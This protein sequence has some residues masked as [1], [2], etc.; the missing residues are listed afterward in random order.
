MTGRR[1]TAAIAANVAVAVFILGSCVDPNAQSPG[2]QTPAPATDQPI[3]LDDTGP[4]AAAAPAPRR[5]R[6]RQPPRRAGRRRRAAV[7]AVEPARRGNAYTDRFARALERHPQP[8][9]RL[10]QPRGRALSRRRD[11]ALRGARLR[12][13][14]DVRG[15][16]LLA[17]A[18]GRL[19]KGDAR[20]GTLDRAWKNMERYI[21]PTQADQPT[22]MAYTDRKPATYAPE[23]DTPAAYPSQLDRQRSGRPRSAGARAAASYGRGAP[24]TACTGSST[25]TTGTASASAATAP[26]P[27]YM[28]TF[29]RGP[30]ESVWET[31]PQPCWDEFKCGRQI[32]L[33]STCS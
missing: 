25:S 29:Q 30:Q 5:P 17:V 4:P 11:A 26:G 16:Q 15:V 20:L 18:G 33:T 32:R 28:N 22:N 27:S 31:I 6:R 3:I 1:I 13:R 8:A 23:G 10:L 9:E 7:A 2:A 14:D 21:I 12:A 24:S 19:R